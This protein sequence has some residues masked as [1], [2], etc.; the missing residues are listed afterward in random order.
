MRSAVPPHP[1]GMTMQRCK[2]SRFALPFFVLV[3]A[4]FAAGA[5]RA[6]QGAGALSGVV[7]DSLNQQPLSGVIVMIKSPALQED[8]IAATDDAGFYRIANLPPGV[9]SI[10]FDKDGF[11]PSQQ[12]GIALRSDVT[13]RVN[14]MMVPSTQKQEDIVL[15]VRPTVDVGSSS[16]S[17]SISAQMI[18]RV[19][20]SAPGGKGAASR[21]IESVAAVAPTASND[22]YGVG[23]NGATSPENHYSVDGLSI[24]NPGKGVLGTQLSSEFVEEVNVVTAGYMPE[25]GRATGGILNVVTKSGSN[26]FHGGAWTY[27][28]PGGLEGE[29]K[30]LAEDLSRVFSQPSLSYIGDFGLDV[31]G[32]ILQDKLWFYAGFD[33]STT[34]FNVTRSFY[35]S[36]PNPAMPGETQI[37]PNPLH[38]EDYVAEARTY[39]AIAKL[40]YSI[41][42]DNRLT[43]SAFGTPTRSGGGAKFDGNTVTPGQYGIDPL[44]GYPESG[45]ASTYSAAAHQYASVPIDASLKWNSQFMGKRLLLDVMVGT[46]YQKDSRRAADGSSALSSSPNELGYHYNVNWRR[47]ADA[48]GGHHLLTE[49][50][51]FPGM[52]RCTA[53]SCDVEDYVSGSPRDLAEATYNRYHSSVIVS[54]LANLFGHHLIKLGIDGELSQY[55]NQKSNRVFAESEDGSQFNDE[56]RFGLLVGPDQFVF[57]DPLTKKTQSL[58]L[59]GFI[60]DSWSVADK[61]TVNLGVRYDAQYFYNT[62]GN[63]GLSLPNQWSPRLGLIW[64]PTQSGRSKL[65]M[66]YARYYENAPLDFADVILVGEPQLHGGHACDPR[67]L[68]MQ[69]NECQ[70]RENLRP[71]SQDDPRPPNQFFTG[72]GLPGTLDPNIKAS[73]SDELS[74]GAEFEVFTDGRVGLN[75]SRR[76]INYWIEDMTPTAGLSGFTGNPGFGLGASM[77]K[78]QRDY[79]AITAFFAKNFSNNWLAQASYTL[80]FLRGN[81]Q[82]LFSEDGYLGPN[83]TADWD[84]PNVPVNRLGALKGD[85]RHTVKVLGSREWVFS[86][87]QSLGTG[88]SLGA[89]SGA[90]TSYLASD[91]Y[92]YPEQAYLVERGIGPRLPWNFGVD[93]RLSYRL[94]TFASTTLSVTADIFNLFNFQRV[95]DIDEV[96]T[97]DNVD[98]I[99]GTK[100]SDL[101]TLRNSDGAPIEKREDNFGKPTDWQAPRVFRFGLRGEF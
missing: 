38:S 23:I 30:R 52:E 71:N 89:R 46:H 14:G 98:P 37:D 87:T 91:K 36:I 57:I 67:V 77:P 49:F 58:T 83:G 73:S 53:D 74:A 80:G 39:Q 11:F 47:R 13:L 96:Y 29:R 50:E 93:V 40:T 8:Q 56:E 84:S 12:G 34:R 66:N 64:D 60:Q 3:V 16:S 6:Q 26:N 51:K 101:G 62:E 70:A 94:A 75:F 10:N 95:T 18:K 22:T 48:P 79:N 65:Y 72:G 86:R 24:G 90:P 78:V 28:S 15:T 59:G 63:I 45:G 68:S 9:Y 43:L 5:A 44:S 97:N 17:T 55:R 61:V 27:V 33:A 85:I 21:T 54:Y 31:G 4:M 99:Q 19:P 82:G 81:Y 7:V 32:P 92:T 35:R 69:R 100:V 2:R 25:F 88:V 41:N 42:A 1:R 76:W 20:M